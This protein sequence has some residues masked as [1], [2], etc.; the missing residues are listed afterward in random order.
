VSDI[1]VEVF[2]QAKREEFEL[3]LLSSTLDSPASITV[4]DIHRPGLA[5]SGFTQNFLSERI[6]ILG[7][8][9]VLYLATLSEA[10]RR[11]AL[12]RIFLEPVPCVI[13]TKAL[14][15]PEPLLSL[16]RERGIPVLRTPM[17]TTPFIHQLTAYLD[18]TFA[19]RTQVHASLVDVY[20][21]GLLFSGR[22]GIGKSECALD[23]VERGHRL[24]A[25]DRVTIVRK[26]SGILMGA[27]N[28]L[29]THHMEIR[30]IGIIDIGSIFG[31]R[32]I[33][34]QKRVEV[35]VRLVDWE[36]G[37]SYERLGIDEVTT[38]ILGIK[39]PLITVGIVPGKNITVIAEVVALNHLLK[40]YGYSSAAALSQ[41]LSELI[42]R[43]ERIA[44]LVSNDPE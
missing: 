37:Q 39:I 8:T 26:P 18:D 10:T 30:G 42:E 28:E 16:A 32:A 19:P 41:R 23:L 7:E 9:E 14:P 2:F 31:V 44:R 11:E 33:R 4:S 27:G 21:V 17:S 24:V 25:D 40:S 3:E 43:K 12:E 22:S 20:G 29:L 38:A 34:M 35:E 5:L 1:T 36:P 15:P 13:I 6:Q